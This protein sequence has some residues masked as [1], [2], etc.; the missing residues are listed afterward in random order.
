MAKKIS[1]Q[2]GIKFPYTTDLNYNYFVDTN[3]N[4]KSKIRSILMHVIFT[5]K[6]QKLR[7]PEFGTDLI[8]MIFETNDASSW[9]NI[10]SE[11]NTAISK[12]LP[13]VTLNN[14]ELAQNEDEPAELF[15]KI[16]YSV[17]MN[18]TVESDSIITSI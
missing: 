6:G 7:D 1:Q 2:Y 5:P 18:G 12:Y 9:G 4:V 13:N 10:K 11:I 17:K 16:E 8:R 15:V 14:I 3:L